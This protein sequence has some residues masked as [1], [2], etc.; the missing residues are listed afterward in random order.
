M[1]ELQNEI[2]THV[3]VYNDGAK[4]Y[5][6]AK[7]YKNIYDDSVNE[8]DGIWLKGKY[9]RFSNI[10]RIITVS[11]YQEKYSKEL[12]VKMPVFPYEN[13][14]PKNSTPRIKALQS[15]IKG[16][17]KVVKDRTEGNAFELMKRMEKSL[18]QTELEA[19]NV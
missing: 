19:R 4:D 9:I 16:I 11:E 10:A 13:M 15:L 18:K 12:P 1:N 6:T 7:D 17:K 8:S 5:L 2:Y 3:V 14:I